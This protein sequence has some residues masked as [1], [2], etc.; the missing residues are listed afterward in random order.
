MAT[1]RSPL[2]GL[3][4]RPSARRSGL[5]R[6]ISPS[7]PAWIRTL[8][9]RST[10]TDRSRSS[11]QTASGRVR[12]SYA[13]KRET[14]WNRA[15]AV[16]AFLA[17]ALSSARDRRLPVVHGGARRSSARSGACL[18]ARSRDLSDGPPRCCFRLR[19]GRPRAATLR[20]PAIRDRPVVDGLP[21][22]HR[23]AAAGRVR[24]RAKAD[25]PRS[26]RSRRALGK[27][28]R[29]LS[30]LQF[31]RDRR[32][33]DRARARAERADGGDAVVESDSRARRRRTARS[34]IGTAASAP[35]LRRSD[36]SMRNGQKIDCSRELRRRRDDAEPTPEEMPAIDPSLMDD[37]SAGRGRGDAAARDRKK[38]EEDESDVAAEHAERDRRRD[39]RDRDRRRHRAETSFR[40]PSC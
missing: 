7:A 40:R 33:V 24:P 26:D 10:T 13:L 4:P 17:G 8:W 20:A 5:R 1:T 14:R 39:R 22:R 6:R 32:R 34:R 21:D 28:R 2:R 9:F 11:D 12:G 3:G 27:L 25:R 15:A 30:A 35:L 29:V 23:G 38:R 37:G 31:V 18:A 36:N 16:R 19:P